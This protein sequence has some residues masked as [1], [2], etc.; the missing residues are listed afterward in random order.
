M[1]EV[2]YKAFRY[3]LY[4]S[5]DVQVT[6]N[7]WFGCCRKVYNETLAEAQKQYELG[8]RKFVNRS[9]MCSMITKLKADGEHDYLKQVP[10]HTLQSSIAN[11]LEAYERFFNSVSGYPKFK[12]KHNSKQ[13]FTVPCSPNILKNC[14]FDNNRVWIPNL[15]KLIRFKQHRLLTGVVKSYTITRESTGK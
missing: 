1:S 9:S 14:Q 8:N 13:S 7:Q 12:S 11:L 2:I 3:R 10:I 5:K 15:K 6:F 4:P